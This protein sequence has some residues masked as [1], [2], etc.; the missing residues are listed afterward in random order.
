MRAKERVR[1]PE[2]HNP[3]GVDGPISV[4]VVRGPSLPGLVRA[5]FLEDWSWEGRLALQRKDGRV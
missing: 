2:P 5:A 4:W 3:M 1:A